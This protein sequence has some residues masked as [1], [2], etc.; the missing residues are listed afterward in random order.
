MAATARLASAAKPA[1]GASWAPYL[2]DMVLVLLSSTDPISMPH[3]EESESQNILNWKGPTR[4]ISLTPGSRQ[5]HAKF[6]FYVC[7]CCP[8]TPQNP[9]AKAM[10]TALRSLFH[11][12]HPPVKNLFL[13]PRLTLL[14]C[15]SMLLEME[16]FLCPT[17]PDKARMCCSPYI[18]ELFQ[19]SFVWERKKS[20]M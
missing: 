4:T 6:K 1:P 16:L 14:W 7:Y 12:H 20:N 11:T 17:I 9:A 3:W 19:T 8:N 13:K 5:E 2:A 18:I 10:P 15:S